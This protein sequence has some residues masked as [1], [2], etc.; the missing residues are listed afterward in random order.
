MTTRLMIG[1]CRAILPTLEADSF[2]C[3]LTSPPYWGLRDYGNE[4][5]IGVEPTLDAYVE[6]MRDVSRDLSRLLKP[7]GTFWLNLGDSYANDGKWGGAS[8]G[9]HV[10]A[11]HGNTGVGRRKVSTG[12]KPK[13]LCGVPWRV[14]FALQAAGWWLRSAIVWHK[15]NPMPESVT[16]RPTS[17]YEMVFLLTKSERYFYDPEAIAETS[18]KAG[19][20]LHSYGTGA[21]DRE[22][23]SDVND[24]RTR[25]GLANWN[26]P[27]PDTKNA[28]NVWTI[29]TQPFKGSHFATMPPDLAERCIKAGCP[30]GGHVLDPFGGSGTTGLV[31]NR[32]GRDATLIDLNP[33]YCNMTAARITDDAP[34]FAEV[35]Q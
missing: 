18:I 8:G 23:V 14:A 19:Q 27:V 31:A 11:L 13:D 29:S 26:K 20:V 7:E 15:P 17:A 30:R 3:I 2:D 6:T 34:L 21:K 12:L 33:G 4:G 25:I 16:D 1:D 24:R 35:L 22:D 10:E 32:L 5:Q 9:K 28:R